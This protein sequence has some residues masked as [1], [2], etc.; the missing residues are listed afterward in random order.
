[1]TEA[2]R[3]HLIWAKVSYTLLSPLSFNILREVCAY[4]LPI[5]L[6]IDIQPV[7]LR[8]FTIASLDWSPAVSLS[9]PIQVNGKTSRWVLVDRQRVVCCGGSKEGKKV[10][11]WSYCCF[12]EGDGTVLDMPN[13]LQARCNH[14]LIQWKCQIL[15]FGGVYEYGYHSKS[16]YIQLGA[17]ETWKALPN[18]S[19]GKANFNPCRYIGR[20]YLCGGMSSTLESFNPLTSTFQTLLIGLPEG[21]CACLICIH[22]GALIVHTRRYVLKY[23]AEG[24]GLKETQRTAKLVSGAWEHSSQPVLDRNWLYCISDSTCWRVNCNTGEQNQVWSYCIEG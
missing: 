24:E 7:A 16:E 9:A 11:F 15:V 12:I 8:F 20:I 2:A 13:M 17:L 1:M 22:T 14:G 18:M 4:L 3:L 10:E 5:V 6:L 19:Q 21:R 23:E